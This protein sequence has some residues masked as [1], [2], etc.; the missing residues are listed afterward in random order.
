MDESYYYDD[1]AVAN[2]SVIVK[3][4][5]S[6]RYCKIIFYCY[7]NSSSSS[8][9]YIRFPHYNTLVYSDNSWNYWEV[10]RQSPS[11]IRVR[12]YY[13]SDPYYWGI[14]TC[15]IPDSNGNTLE[16]CAGVYSSMPS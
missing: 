4:P 10:Y 13:Y 2:N 9:G 14:L 1:K 15:E 16:I 3:K 12:N 6:C 8:V 7:S 11:G 5:H